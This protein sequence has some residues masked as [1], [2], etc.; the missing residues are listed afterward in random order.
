MVYTLD[1]VGDQWILKMAVFDNGK[2]MTPEQVLA[3]TRN[4]P[5][6][7]SEGADAEKSFGFGL[8]Q[9]KKMISLENG[10]F[11]LESEKGKCTLFSLLSPLPCNNSHQI[12]KFHF[13]VNCGTISYNGYS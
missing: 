7:R 13:I 12:D 3:F 11:K 4:Q 1:D 5:A 2:S 8:Q 10:Q 6:A 9:V